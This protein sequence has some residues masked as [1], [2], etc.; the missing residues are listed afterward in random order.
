MLQPAYSLLENVADIWKF[1]STWPGIYGR[2]CVSR[3]MAIGY[4]SRVG[5]LVAGRYGV[6]QYRLRC[7]IWGARQGMPLPGF[8]MP[9]H[10]VVRKATVMPTELRGCKVL[11]PPGRR[12]W[13]EVR[14]GDILL[15]FPEIENEATK[16]DNVQ[17]T[18]VNPKWRKELRLDEQR[19]KKGGGGGGGGSKAAAA[20]GQQSD[21][22]SYYHNPQKVLGYYRAGAGSTL[23]N[24]VPLKMNADDKFRAEHIPLAKGANWSDLG[25]LSQDKKQTA[26]HFK[27]FAD[28]DNNEFGEKLPPGGGRS[29]DKCIVPQVMA[30][31]PCHLL[32]S[33]P[34]PSIPIECCCLSGEGCSKLT[35]PSLPTVPQYAVNSRVANK[36]YKDALGR[37]WWDEIYPTCI[38][39]MQIHSHKNQHPGQPRSFS[40]REYARMQGFPDTHF[41]CG[42]QPKMFEQ[43]RARA[44]GRPC[45]RFLLFIVRAAV[46]LCLALRFHGPACQ[47]TNLL[48][49]SCLPFRSG[50]RS[51]P[52]WPS[53]SARR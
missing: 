45:L 15:D 33:P 37:A 19:R 6:P 1:P 40:A 49:P 22:D 17:Y 31:Q 11:A 41:L 29:A 30:I 44:N 46:C 36:G 35:V 2:F 16:V 18:G 3:H 27:W 24:H 39:R 4:Q 48:L 28:K 10:R 42:D 9:T 8:P 38:C 32:T 12:L 5:F 20:A 53:T 34:P 25:E 7:F 26:R 43:V 50:M 51:A 13:R 14:I 23:T 47:R 52:G 21:Q